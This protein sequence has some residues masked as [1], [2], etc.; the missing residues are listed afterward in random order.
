MR[1]KEAQFLLYTPH[2]FPPPLLAVPSTLPLALLF[3]Q[4]LVLFIL[5]LAYTK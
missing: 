3:V 5:R 1:N 2:A 4:L